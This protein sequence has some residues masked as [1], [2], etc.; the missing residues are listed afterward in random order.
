MGNSTEQ[1]LL[2]FIMDK[3][4]NNDLILT[5]QNQRNSDQ[6]LRAS[7]PLDAMYK[8]NFSAIHIHSQ[9]IVRIFGKGAPEV[10]IEHC[11]TVLNEEGKVN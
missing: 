4:R 8:M 3:T 11:T 1:G 5:K 9:G 7:I 2:R 6:F 10:L